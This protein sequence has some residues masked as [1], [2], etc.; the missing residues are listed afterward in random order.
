MWP[1][2]HRRTPFACTNWLEY[3]GLVSTQTIPRET[4]SEAFSD[5][6][7]I[8]LPSGK[9]AVPHNMPQSSDLSQSLISLLLSSV[10]LPCF[11][12]HCLHVLKFTTRSALL[13]HP[14]GEAGVCRPQTQ[15]VS[16]VLMED[17]RRVGSASVGNYSESFVSRTSCGN[18]RCHRLS[19]PSAHPQCI[20]VS[21]S[22]LR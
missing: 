4:P 12:L 8:L 20:S 17:A 19:A 5:L 6:L 10:R 3:L 18:L 1:L 15:G 11:H 13:P 16:H 9:S 2:S 14:N 7:S 21:G 22:C